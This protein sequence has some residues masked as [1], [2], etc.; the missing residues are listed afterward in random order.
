MR[1][2]REL[3]A[4]LS[5]ART[6]EEIHE[7]AAR[8]AAVLAATFAFVLMSGEVDTDSLPIKRRMSKQANEYTNETL[9]RLAPLQLEKAGKQLQP[10]EKIRYLICDED[11]HISAECVRPQE[12]VG[13]DTATMSRNTVR[14]WNRPSRKRC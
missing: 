9:A 11:A 3:L 1:A 12:L 14:Y 6:L 4:L 10:E 5:H 8:E 13:A 7:R 2:Q